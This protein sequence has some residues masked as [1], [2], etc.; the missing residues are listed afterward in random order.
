MEL[1]FRSC[2]E[3]PRLKPPAPLEV[4]MND[5]CSELC[6][7]KASQSRAVIVSDILACEIHPHETDS[8]LWWHEQA[9]DH[10][11][12]IATKAFQSATRKNQ[13]FCHD[14]SLSLFIIEF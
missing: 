12:P 8:I 5:I 4:M 14:S 13:T 11:T 2:G 1:W 10:I 6:W 9:N 7:K 3:A